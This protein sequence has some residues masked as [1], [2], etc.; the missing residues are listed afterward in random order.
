[1]KILFDVGANWGTSSL[2]QIEK[3]EDW[4][5]FAFEPTPRLIEH[6]IKESASFSDR[7]HI[8]P[9]AVSDFDGEADFHIAGQADWGCSSLLNFN[10]N[11]AEMWPG[12]KDFKVTETIKVK[13]ITL[14]TFI[15]Q[16]TDTEIKQIDHYHCDVQGSD[17]K[18]LQGLGE[19]INIIQEG[20]VE[21]AVKKDILYI[22]QNTAEDTDA[23]LRKHNFL[24]SF[25]SNDKFNNETNIRFKKK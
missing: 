5:C 2:R 6:M 14:K 22:N 13:A 20:E 4:I 7:Y 17:L 18:A 24:T 21:A 12:R 15:E 25:H 23:Y 9:C 1:M 19:Y 10:S 3:N 8:I 16:M 11:L